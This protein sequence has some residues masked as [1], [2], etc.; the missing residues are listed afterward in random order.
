[1]VIVME[2]NFSINLRRLR[3]ERGLTQEQ[4]ADAVGVSA[5]AVSKWEQNGFPDTPLLPAIADSLDVSIDELFGRREDTPDIFNQIIQ[6]LS[7]FSSEER[8][9]HAFDLCWAIS[10]SI[11]GLT[12]YEPI[13]DD[14]HQSDEHQRSECV[15]SNGFSQAKIN[16]TLQYFLLIPEPENGYDS[17]FPYNECYVKL[18]E[19]LAFPDALRALYFLAEAANL[20]VN[21]FFTEQT[22]A[23]SLSIDVTHA[24]EILEKLLSLSLIE[25][26]SLDTGG[27]KEDIFIS[28]TGCDFISFMT[29]T[30]MLLNRTRHYCYQTCSRSTSLF[31]NA[32]YRNT[33]DT[34]KKGCD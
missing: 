24:R 22:L 31:R 21:S 29:F 19:I 4:L 15:M 6:Y 2:Q 13:K 5:Q 10:E 17:F 28:V 14:Y 11:F 16:H 32:S 27:K 18:F 30:H 8:I 12:Q 23:H 34:A 7:S 1:M 20:Y 26:A 33:S 9:R 3:K 25:K